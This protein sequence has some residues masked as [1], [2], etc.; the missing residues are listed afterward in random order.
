MGSR[1]KRVHST[2]GADLMAWL[3]AWTSEEALTQCLFVGHATLGDSSAQGFIRNIQESCPFPKGLGYALVTGRP[4]DTFVVCLCHHVCPTAI[5]WFVMPVCIYA[6]D[7]MPVGARS[8]ISRKSMEIRAPSVAHANPA[9]A[10]I[11][12]FRVVWVVATT[13]RCNPRMIFPTVMLAVF[14]EPSDSGL[15]QQASAA[16]GFSPAKPH[17][18]N[19]F[20]GAA[21]TPTQPPGCASIRRFSRFQYQQSSEALAGQIEPSR[22]PHDYSVQVLTRAA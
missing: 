11:G 20:D 1:A 22:H 15:T 4:H 3:L 12:I 9:T 18:G 6:V 21:I 8:H 19:D 7:R 16:T 13:F 14:R 5:A 2:K 17:H 10:V